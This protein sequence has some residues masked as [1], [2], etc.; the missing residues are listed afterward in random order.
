MTSVRADPGLPASAA[1]TDA[2][3]VLLLDP[4]AAGARNG[5]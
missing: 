5:G 3:G 4:P 1:S 2:P